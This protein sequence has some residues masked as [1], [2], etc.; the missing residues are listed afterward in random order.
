MPDSDGVIANCG[1]TRRAVGVR[2]AMTPLDVTRS[3]HPGTGGVKGPATG[4][5][6]S[7][8]VTGGSNGMFRSENAV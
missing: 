1:V 3:T 8:G 5:V 2:F 4:Y 7:D 6:G